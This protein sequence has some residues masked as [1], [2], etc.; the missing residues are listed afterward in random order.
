MN[1]PSSSDDFELGVRYELGQGVDKDLTKA[2][3][4]Y[5]KAAET[6]NAAALC[7]LGEL[8]MGGN[9]VN[10]DFGK[11]IGLFTKAA[12]GGS[13]KAM[14]NLGMVYLTGTGAERDSIQA[15]DWFLKAADMG[16]SAAYTEL[17][18]LYINGDGVDQDFSEAGKWLT[19][20]AES[21]DSLSQYKVGY[22]YE[23]G[24]GFEKDRE[25]AFGWYMKAAEQNI[26]D[27]QFKV[28]S[29]LVAESPSL[30][31]EEAVK[32]YT[33]ASVLGFL[34]A[35]VNLGIMKYTRA[36]YDDAF[37][38]FNSAAYRNDPDAQFYLGRLYIEGKGVK[39]DID[40]GV[41]WLR[42]SA[43]NGNK[44]AKDVIERVEGKK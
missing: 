1:E 24:I 10:R 43:G 35:M 11:G 6:G 31:E 32:W 22:M 13:P 41:K 33:K 20:A 3:E 18:M 34:P 16:E 28:A 42:L 17:G 29:I 37:K 21:G 2:A 9:G 38:W 15:K 12:E 39:K 4:C 7:A 27:A 8:Y 14:L 40:L 19:K 44:A 5:E 26:P 25:K 36:E 23:E 30:N